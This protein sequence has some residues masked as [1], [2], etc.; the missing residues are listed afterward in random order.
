[1]KSSRFGI[2]LAIAGAF[3][4]QGCAAA[5]LAGAALDAATG[6]PGSVSQ[7][8]AT[9]VADT[10]VVKGTQALII[11]NNAYQGVIAVGRVYLETGNPTPTTLAKLRELNDSALVALEKGAAG[12]SL[13][14][15][16]AD[17]FNAVAGMQAIFGRPN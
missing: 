4:L 13:A 7:P 16:A 5:S 11:A 6:P 17:V 12:Q 10:V 15:R 1:M 8:V 9:T 14:D 3:A 2:L